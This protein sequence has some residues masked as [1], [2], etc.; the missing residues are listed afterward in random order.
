MKELKHL[1]TFEKFN[2]DKI[3]PITIITKYISER[4]LER[5][6]NKIKN[7]TDEEQIE[8]INKILDNK[9]NNR[10]R[11]SGISGLVL[12]VGLLAIITN[13]FAHELELW[14]TYIFIYDLLKENRDFIENYRN[15]L[16]EKLD[17][18]TE[19]VVQ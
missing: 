7:K 9:D 16:Q 13:G 11:F 6:K 5:I 15:Q 8:I 17:E 4:N 2:W 3:N 10:K 12:G 19:I 1:E 18:I 14:L